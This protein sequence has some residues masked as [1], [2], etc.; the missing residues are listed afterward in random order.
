M[1]ALLDRLSELLLALSGRE[2]VLI[3]LLAVIVL[4]LGMIYGVAIP[5]AERREAARATT[6]EAR[7]TELW[8]ADQAVT[9]AELSRD[10][11]RVSGVSRAVSAI[12]L[13][14]I[15]ASLRDVGLRKAASELSNTADGGVTLQFDSVRFTRLADWLTAQRDVWGY[16]LVGFTFERGP[17]EDV[18][19]ADLR[20]EPSQ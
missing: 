16:D 17:R 19:S 4:P 14:G 5:L 15:E 12:G 20:L 18:I 2:R 9:F 1:S 6:A 7:A 13:S 8:V 3:A 10:V 11:A